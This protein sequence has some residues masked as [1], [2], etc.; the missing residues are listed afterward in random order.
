MNQ[1]NTIAFVATGLMLVGFGI[2][3]SWLFKP[4]KKLVKQS[5]KMKRRYLKFKKKI[6]KLEAFR[7]NL[8]YQI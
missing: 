6:S 4:L 2:F 3:F 7:K 5:R 1:L 8:D